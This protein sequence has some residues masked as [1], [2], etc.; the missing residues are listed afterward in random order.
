METAVFANGRLYDFGNYPMLIDAGEQ[1]VKGMIVT[2]ETEYYDAI[3]AR[4]DGLEGYNSVKPE[5]SEYVRVAREVLLENGR[6]LT[7]WLYIGNLR[8]EPTLPMVKDGD[9]ATYIAHKKDDIHEWWQS[10]NTVSGLHKDKSGERI[11]D[12]E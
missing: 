2:V 9:W 11:V 10:V 12:N 4:L 3:M 1:S 5:E 8:F 7:A 6:S